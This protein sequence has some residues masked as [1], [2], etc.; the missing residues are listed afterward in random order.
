MVPIARRNLVHDRARLVLVVL[1]VAV[2]V[3]LI[4][5]NIGMLLYAMDRAAIYIAHVEADLWVTR[6]GSDNITKRSFIPSTTLAEVARHPHVEAVFPLIVADVSGIP[7]GVDGALLEERSFPLTLVGYETTTGVGGPWALQD[8]GGVRHPRANEMILDEKV[9][10]E[11]KILVGDTIRVGEYELRVIALSRDTS[12]LTEKMGFV[13]L[14]TA[15]RILMTND[16][17]YVLARVE[18]KP[19]AVRHY[20]AFAAPEWEC[21][22]CDE[23]AA[24]TEL[25]VLSRDQFLEN[26]VGVWMQWIGVWIVAMGVVVLAV[27]A[28]VILLATYTATVEKLPE[29]G[30]LKAIGASN[31]FVAL[32]VLKQTLW[33]ATI[34]FVLGVLGTFAIAPILSRLFDIDILLNVPVVLLTYLAVIAFSALAAFVAMRKAVTVD[35]LMV[36]HTRY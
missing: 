27:A 23:L 5:Y 12:T 22:I 28:V 7:L 35:P 18:T 34:G 9:A 16:I 25:D 20:N 17:S 13:P 2:T 14:E 21:S 3:T 30:V 31:R 15:Q 11:N 26:S 36:F 19:V 1:G 29:F 6:P 24:T 4:L 33:G 32:I 10:Q 8:G